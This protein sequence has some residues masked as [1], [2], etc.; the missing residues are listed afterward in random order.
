MKQNRK[1]QIYDYY[2]ERAPEYEEIYTLGAG[3]ASISD[4]SAYKSEFKEVSELI[5]N[6]TGKNHIDIACGTAA[7]LPYYQYSCTRITLIDQS[8]NLIF[9][10]EP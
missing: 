4:P 7:W 10:K 9:R 2:N 3:P 6:N 1:K 8:K 5:S